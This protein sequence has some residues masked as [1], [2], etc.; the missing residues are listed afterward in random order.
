MGMWFMHGLFFALVLSGDSMVIGGVGFRW[1][2]ACVG[3]VYACY[4]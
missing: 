2:G 1:T 3:R 4:L